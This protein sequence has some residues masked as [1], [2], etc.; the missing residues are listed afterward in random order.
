MP[1]DRIDRDRI[2]P[3]EPE[4]EVVRKRLNLPYAGDIDQGGGALKKRLVSFAVTLLSLFLSLLVISGCGGPSAESPGAERALSGETGKGGSTYYVSPSGDDSNP[5]TRDSP[6]ASPGFGSKQLKAGDTM[7]ILGG[8]YGLK[9]F[10][11][12]MITPPS[13]TAESWTIIKGEEGNRPVLAGRDDL[14]SAVDIPGKSYLRIENLEITSDGGADFRCGITGSGSPVNHVV[15]KDLYIHHIDEAAA[16]F[17][18]VE[19]L[20]VTGCVMSHCGFGCLM[21]PAGEQGGWRNVV[22]DG[23]T[24]SYSGHYYRGGPGPSPYDRPDGFGIEPSRGPIEIKNTLVEHNRGDGLDSKPANTYIHEC[25]VANNSCD[26]V[27]LWDD[28]SRVVNTLV[29]GT[30]DGV[31]GGSPWAG[32]VLGGAPDARF[33][34]VNVTVHDNP[35]REAY[36]MYVDYEGQTPTTVVMSNCIVANGQGEVHFGDSV[37]LEADHNIFYRPSGDSQVYANGRQYS[38]EQVESGAL[39]EANISRDPRFSAPAWGSTG[40]YHLKANSPA[41]DA[42]TPAGAPPIDLD[43]NRRPAG[44]GFD[45]GAYEYGSGEIDARTR[46]WGH[47]SIGVAALSSEW[48]M[49]EGCTAGG[50]E[51]WVLVANP[52]DEEADVSVGY[53]TGEGPVAGPDLTLGPGTRRTVKVSDTVAESWQVSTSVSSNREVVAERSM[54]WNG[55]SAAHE[56]IGSPSSSRKWYL[57]EGSTGGDFETWVLVANAGGEVANVSLTYMTD[58]GTV[59]GPGF[60]LAAGSRHTVNVAG[61]VPGRWSVATLVESDG[62]VVAERA[63]YWGGRGGGHSSVGAA[64]ARDRWYLAEGST[65]GDFETWVLVQNPGAEEARVELTY[66]TDSGEVEGPNLTLSPGTRRTLDVAQ[67]VPGTWSVSTLVEADGPVVAERAMYWGGRREGHDSIGVTTPATCWYL[68][69][70]STGPG[71]ETW[72]LVQNPGDESSNVKLDYLTENGEVPGPRLQLEGRSR[73]TVCV[74][75]GLPDTWSVSAVVTSDRPVIAERA[76][77]GYTE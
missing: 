41:I 32:V 42:G 24:L 21:G 55:R 27:K 7:V 63:M 53:M 73:H 22:V 65:G 26:G 33:E 61:D 1:A 59:D 25:I 50:F 62:P 40:D 52:G 64:A 71:F 47:D 15:L 67:S 16:D 2:K 58:T 56:S 23:C 34:L 43:G 5:G 31:G 19:D 3:S 60:Q 51:T 35:S 12:D 70:G 37:T 45:I 49:S 46:T 18:D 28:N 20:R 77:Y 44:S 17:Q 74:N 66:F 72:V 54:Y 57:A 11:D 8:T 76:M 29:Y 48:S 38:A 36:P 9:T 75:S 30:G 13:G 69:E 6:W 14:F 4:A 39:G 68:A 10:Y